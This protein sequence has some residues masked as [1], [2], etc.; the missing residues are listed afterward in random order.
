MSDEARLPV[1]GE[2][3]TAVEEFRRYVTAGVVPSTYAI[4]RALGG[5]R[6]QVLKDLER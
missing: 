6:A 1:E 4:R 2:V 3:L 5:E